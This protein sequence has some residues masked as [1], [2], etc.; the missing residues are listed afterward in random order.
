MVLNYEE[1]LKKVNNDETIEA[2]WIILKEED[3]VFENFI[4]A[5]FFN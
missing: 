1:G 4:S 5:G 2:L 3:N